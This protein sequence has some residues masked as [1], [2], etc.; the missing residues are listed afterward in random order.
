M[1][2]RSSSRQPFAWTRKDFYN[3][4][5]PG[6]RQLAE[7]LQRVCRH[8]IIKSPDGSTVLTHPT[9]AQAAKHLYVGETSLTRYLTGQYVPS[10]ETITSIYETACRD[11]GGE[12]SLGVT[13]EYLLELRACAEQERCGSCARHREEARAARQERAAVLEDQK[14]LTDKAENLAAEFRELRRRYSLLKQETLRIRPAAE[15]GPRNRQPEEL[16]AT[17]LPVPS[18]N[19]DRQRSMKDVSAA[20]RI[21]RRAEELAGGGQPDRVLALLRHTVEACTSQEMALL[22]ALLRSRGQDELAGNF[23]HIYA[24]DRSYRDVLRAA[25]VLHEQD[26]VAD[27]E[28]L[29][30]AA[31]ARP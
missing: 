2:A 21:R 30:R 23:V 27:A 15:A 26:V 7:A 31:A 1:A 11:A 9:Q 28:A 13:K 19:G 18:R 29:L 6:R 5:S 12:Q 22:V 16:A 24:R 8:L 25:L 10:R 17:P 14:R 3:E 4:A 20:Q